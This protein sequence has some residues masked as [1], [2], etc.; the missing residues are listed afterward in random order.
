MRAA[1][2]SG[3][4]DTLQVLL[5]SRRRPPLSPLKK[6]PSNHHPLPPTG[7]DPRTAED[8]HAS[9]ILSYIHISLL[10]YFSAAWKAPQLCPDW[11]HGK[12]V[13][14]RT[15]QSHGTQPTLEESD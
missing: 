14:R 5:L 12:N 9:A 10:F 6:L 1:T 7:L 13:D 3:K 4:R 2:L 15:T 11:L 8:S